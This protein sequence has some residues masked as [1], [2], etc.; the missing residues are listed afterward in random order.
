MT[1]TSVSS[2][3]ENKID[4]DFILHT[5]D[6]TLDEQLSSTNDPDN[7]GLTAD[8]MVVIQDSEVAFTKW[9]I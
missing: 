6:S 4:L 3:D 8:D 2:P 9:N 7:I 5:N 1:L